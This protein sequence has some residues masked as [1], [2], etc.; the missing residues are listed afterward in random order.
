MSC[1]NSFRLNGTSRCLQLQ[2]KHPTQFINKPFPYLCQI[3][4]LTLSGLMEHQDAYNPYPNAL[5]SLRYIIEVL[6]ALLY[7]YYKPF[8]VLT[9]SGLMEHQDA[10]NPYPNALLSLRYIIEVG[11]IIIGDVQVEPGEVKE[12]DNITSHPPQDKQPSTETEDEVNI[13]YYNI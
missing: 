6:N 8:L 5:L 10:Y 11:K 9:L 1:F 13:C 3:P 4:V 2:P 12:G 7:L